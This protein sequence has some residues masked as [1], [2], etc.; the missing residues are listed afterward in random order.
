[1]DFKNKFVIKLIN[2]HCFDQVEFALPIKSLFIKDKNGAGKTSLLSAIYSVLTGQPWPNTKFKESLK[3]EQIYFGLQTNEKDWFL[4]GKYSANM[5]FLAQHSLPENLDFGNLG[6]LK[7]IKVLTYT[8]NENLWFS[9]P[10]QER[11][12]N[13]DILLGQIYGQNYLEI[14]KNLEKIIRHKQKIL[15]KIIQPDLILLKTINVKLAQHSQAL[16]K[17]RLEFLQILNQSLPEF[18]TWINSDLKNLQAKITTYSP[19]GVKNVFLHKDNYILGKEIYETNW[20]ELTKK[21]FLLQRTMFGAGKDDFYL[22]IN[23]LEI[24]QVLSR[25]EMRSLVLFIKSIA[26][27]SLAKNYQ[28][29]WLLDDIFNE[30]DDVR[31]QKIFIKILKKTDWFVAT[32]TK[33]INLKI[34]T[35]SLKQL[36]NKMS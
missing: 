29:I 12:K 14:V 26:R 19:F 13:L 7:N 11:L 3:F 24:N 23:G 30:L 5:R 9:L 27:R 35:Y 4:A 18:S 17:Y 31:E 15:K 34:P 28:V 21:E 16:W 22:T 33:K 25:G 2:W 32:G 10:R 36:Q 6:E 20:E 1:M 8:P